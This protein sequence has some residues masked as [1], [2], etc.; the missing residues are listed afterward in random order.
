[1]E[2]KEETSKYETPLFEEAKSL[3]FP[4]KIWKA[5]GGD[6]SC[7]QCSGCHGCR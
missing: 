4:E 3:D 6:Q 1:M 2:A 7:M 5:L